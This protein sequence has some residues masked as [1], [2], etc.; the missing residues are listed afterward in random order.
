MS[1]RTSGEITGT[2]GGAASGGTLPLDAR[3]ELAGTASGDWA[4]LAA[5]NADAREATRI[6]ATAEEE[7][8]ESTK[9][10][11]YFSLLYTF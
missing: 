8:K 2:G 6:N 7:E 11:P 3:R 4:S 10:L 9:L 5:G 1:P